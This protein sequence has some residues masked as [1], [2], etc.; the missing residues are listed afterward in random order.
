MADQRCACS[1]MARADVDLEVLL[2]SKPEAPVDETVKETASRAT[3]NDRLAEAGSSFLRAAFDLVGEIAG[4]H[5]AG[6]RDAALEELRSTLDV[7]VVPEE[8]GKRRLSIAIPS[9]DALSGLMRGLA[10]LLAGESG[11]DAPRMEA[12][13]KSASGL[14]QGTRSLN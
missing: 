11:D 10:R 14:R 7:K 9:R 12:P 13:T 4:G 6:R 1:V 8:H 5:G 3:A 2:G